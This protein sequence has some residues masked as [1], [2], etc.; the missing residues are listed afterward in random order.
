M[1]IYYDFGDSGLDLSY[2]YENTKDVEDE[3]FR[4]KL[5]SKG[6][7]PMVI[8]KY[9]P[10]NTT[11]MVYRGGSIV[12]AGSE[13]TSA[14]RQAIS[15]IVDF[16]K[17]NAPGVPISMENYDSDFE[18][19]MQDPMNVSVMQAVVRAPFQ[20][21]LF[22]LATS[23]AYSRFV[24]FE[25]ERNAMAI[26]RGGGLG[27]NTTVN[28]SVNGNVLFTCKGNEDANKE[29]I[30]KLWFEVLLPKLELFKKQAV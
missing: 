3:N 9:V 26:W 13:N 12:T 1:R 5:P 16:I 18:N 29:R 2:I 23:A 30:E 28:I 14:A 24:E 19:E 10:N 15:K 6:E 21:N 27:P 22:Q 7:T 25:P 20:I 4:V 17:Q 11:A 8:F